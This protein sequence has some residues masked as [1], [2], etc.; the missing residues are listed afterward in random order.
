MANH[1]S[2]N[3]VIRKS[4]DPTHHPLRFFWDKIEGE[5]NSGCWLWTGS[6]NGRYPKIWDGRRGHVIYAHVFAWTVLRGPV[7]LGYDVDHLCRVKI[8]VNPQHLEPVTRRENLR[9]S[10]ASRRRPGAI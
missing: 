2:A 9:R 5:P 3:P 1:R 7:P 4:P 10:A 8:C 6:L